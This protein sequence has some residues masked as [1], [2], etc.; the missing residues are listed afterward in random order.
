[1]GPLLIPATM[2]AGDIKFCLQLGF[3][4]AKKT[5]GTKIGGGLG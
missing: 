5:V 1:M 3:E 4:D 2:E